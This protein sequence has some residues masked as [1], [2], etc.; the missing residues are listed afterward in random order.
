ML[1]VLYSAF[2]VVLVLLGISKCP[3][4]YITFQLPLLL[5]SI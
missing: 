2:H 5:Y 3:A 4:L 1:Y